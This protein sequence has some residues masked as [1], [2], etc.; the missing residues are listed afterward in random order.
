MNVSSVTEAVAAPARRASGMIRPMVRTDIP[1]ICELFIRTFRA[2]KTV[3]RDELQASFEDLLLT[4][5]A[6]IPE[7]SSIVHVDAQGRLDGFWGV[8]NITLRF[9]DRDL[10]GGILCC[11]MA[12]RPETNPVIGLS[13]I[14]AMV[15]GRLDVVFGD[16]ANQIALSLTHPMHFTVLP[17]QSLD[18]FKILRPA[19]VAAHM[20]GRR[21]PPLAGALTAIAG[22]VDRMLPLKS[23]TSVDERSLRGSLDRPIDA[24]AFIAAA[25]GL[26]AAPALGPSWNVAE[27][28]WILARAGQ[29]QRNGRLHIR[30][31]IGRDGRMAGI[32]LMYASPGGVAHA[33]Q[34]L[35]REG[36]EQ[37]V[38]GSMIQQARALGAVAIH[39]ATSREV[40]H[41]L[42]RQPAIFYRHFMSTTMWAADPEVVA[43]IK[44]G[45]VFVGG[46][47]GETWTRI[48]SD[49]FV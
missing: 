14:R 38:A 48:F 12:D 19:G 40:L 41:G 35:A 49:S 45:D 5:P 16:T 11:L 30:E 1:D 20:V 23:L 4:S 33:L 21:L 44:A 25:P 42:L 2:G 26:V 39:G 10:R 47:M 15:D 22:A 36:R 46:L 43:A 32:Y 9:R 17:L 37:V 24:A 18:W 7:R 13:L 28:S 3:R 31:V 27:F 8:I 34:M 6:Y 29:Q